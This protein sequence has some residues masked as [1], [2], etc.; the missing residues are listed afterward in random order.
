MDFNY[1]NSES[2]LCKPKAPFPFTHSPTHLQFFVFGLVSI[3]VGEE[4]HKETR[5]ELQLF[6]AT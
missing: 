6:I 1:N 5:E 2:R 3:S 4:N